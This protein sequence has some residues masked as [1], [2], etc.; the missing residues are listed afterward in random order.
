[1]E[2]QSWF[3]F[4]CETKKK[5]EKCSFNTPEIRLRTKTG[6]IRQAGS[7]SACPK[8][9]EV[10]AVM[11]VC[12]S[13]SLRS[14]STWELSSI[15]K[16][17]YPSACLHLM[18]KVHLCLLQIAQTADSIQPLS[19]SAGPGWVDHTPCGWHLHLLKSL[20]SKQRHPDRMYAN[21]V[22][23]MVCVSLCRGTQG[24]GEGLMASSPAEPMG[25]RRDPVG[26]LPFG[27]NTLRERIPGVA[28]IFWGLDTAFPSRLYQLKLRTH[29]RASQG[30]TSCVC[31]AM[32][33]KEEVQKNSDCYIYE[34]QGIFRMPEPLLGKC[35]GS[36]MHYKAVLCP[37][38]LPRS[39]S[40]VKPDVLLQ[41]LFES[42]NWF[43]RPV[44]LLL[45][46]QQS[47]IQP[48]S[49]AN[50]AVCIRIIIFD[51]IF[52]EWPHNGTSTG[53]LWWKGRSPKDHPPHGSSSGSSF[54]VERTRKGQVLQQEL[55][56]R[57]TH[58]KRMQRAL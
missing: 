55:V 29:K 18:Q 33:H 50:M 36:E 28:G 58:R 35:L 1:M 30:I 46:S 16:H 7:F 11:L 20:S 14:P 51:P 12:L 53:N 44:I 47:Q 34:S 17:L 49:W 38:I 37:H 31:Y 48:F 40:R 4:R 6:Y 25:R 57:E 8:F 39:S 41:D 52:S 9:W 13:G 27:E 56:L 19:I 54:L 5:S 10:P 15:L 24:E 45:L 42:C 26:H 43:S 21:M 3:V 32:A 22:A 2:S 23:N